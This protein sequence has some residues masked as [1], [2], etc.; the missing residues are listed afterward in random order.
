MAMNLKKHNRVFGALLFGGILMGCGG[1]DIFTQRVEIIRE[2]LVDE[3]CLGG[4]CIDEQ[5]VAT[6]CES[7]EECGPGEVCLQGVCEALTLVDCQEGEMPIPRLSTNNWDF[8]NVASGERVTVG[9]TL[10]NLGTCNL[11][12]SDFS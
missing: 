1:S 9:I 4:V 5:C 10:E 11:E 2:C 7:D 12:I 8:G 3:D 6:G